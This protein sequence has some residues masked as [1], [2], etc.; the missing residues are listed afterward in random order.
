MEILIFGSIMLL[1]YVTDRGL[2]AI[3]NEIHDLKETM[4]QNGKDH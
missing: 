3:A 1:A 4:I 2:C